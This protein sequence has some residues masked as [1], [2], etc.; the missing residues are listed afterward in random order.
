M[1]KALLLIFYAL[2]FMVLGKNLSFIPQIPFFKQD[3]SNAVLKEKVDKVLKESKGKF[4]LYYQDIATGESF[5]V[6]EHAQLTA[7]SLNKVVIVGYLYYLAGKGKINL[8]D[9]IAVQRKDIQ[10]YGTGSLRYNGEGKIYS[11]RTLAEL[12][13]KESDNTAAH[14][15]ELRLGEKNVQDFARY[16]GL[17]ST[18]M[19]NN[20]TTALDMSSLFRLIWEKKLTTPSLTLEMLDYMKDTL[21][22]D[23]IARSLKK[24]T[25]FHKSGDGINF[26][27]DTGIVQDEK[28]RAFLLSVLA[29]DVSDEEAAKAAIGRISKTIYDARGN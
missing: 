10:D 13:L 8:E 28:G 27:H 26:I 24:A 17:S 25:V 14:L 1:R 11:L 12:A 15:L 22:E 18:E 16:L 9:K 3:S 7:A 5:G 20:K 19:A 2:F 4:S 21:F 23:R 6:N 29:Y